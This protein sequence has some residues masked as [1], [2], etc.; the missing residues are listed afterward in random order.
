MIVTL[1]Q[2]IFKEPENAGFICS[3]LSNFKISLRITTNSKKF[4]LFSELHSNIPHRNRYIPTTQGY[5]DYPERGWTGAY[6][7][8]IKSK[9]ANNRAGMFLQALSLNLESHVYTVYL[10]FLRRIHLTKISVVRAI[11]LIKVLSYSL[12]KSH[13]TL[14]C[15][16]HLELGETGKR[17]SNTQRSITCM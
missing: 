6:T 7:S 15:L 17:I 2:Y 1:S 5:N 14:L 4:K 9:R 12:Q 10:R 16:S 11:R 13:L 3:S 8:F